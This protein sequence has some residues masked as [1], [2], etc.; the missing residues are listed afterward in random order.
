MITLLSEGMM[1]AH[2]VGKYRVLQRAYPH[3]KRSGYEFS[4]WK[5][6]NEFMVKRLELPIAERTNLMNKYGENAFNV[7]R[8]LTTAMETE[9]RKIAA[10]TVS[11]GMSSREATKAMRTAFNKTG[12]SK[13][14]PFVIETVAR[15]QLQLAYNAGRWNTYQDPA[16][17]EILWGFE[18]VT[19]GDDRVRTDHIALDG[20]RWPKESP[21]WSSYWPPNGYNCRCSTVEIFKGEKEADLKPFEPVKEADGSTRA[22]KPDKGWDFNGGDVFKE[23]S[24]KLVNPKTVQG[25]VKKAVKK[26]TP[27]TPVTPLENPISLYAKL[28]E[29][30]TNMIPESK[31]HG[32]GKAQDNYLYDRAAAREFTVNASLKEVPTDEIISKQLIA[33]R[34]KM[35]K[36]FGFSSADDLA[37]MPN[38]EA[39]IKAIDKY[40]DSKSVNVAA[41]KDILTQNIE[42]FSKQ[43]AA[44][45]PHLVKAREDAI[46]FF[47]KV[48]SKD[49]IQTFAYDAVKTNYR[50][51]V[52]REFYS[53]K[54]VNFGK[55][56]DKQTVFHEYAHHF[57][58]GNTRMQKLTNGW[59]RNRSNDGTVDR[60]A[61]FT[62]YTD[63]E[64]AFK[65]LF[66]T[67]YTGKIYENGFTEV[68]STGVEEMA[69]AASRLKH[70][71][72]DFD[73]FNF[74]I[75]ALSGG[76]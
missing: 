71:M 27:K 73:H 74:V 3:L 7:T 48:S 70:A 76:I 10:Q 22:P 24:S 34:K 37:A 4:I 59:L 75:E 21:F 63:K 58:H 54:T 53:N 32:L 46:D 33:I 20:S 29:E 6:A 28:P 60:L 16:I 39:R 36:D 5:S 45:Q 42:P 26:V 15:T 67:P 9:A 50:G 40:I 44:K 19:V 17:Q 51:N 52:T 72:G 57:E 18:Y 8:N 11:E 41:K 35:K 12:F 62:N 65:D 1:F 56:T 38:D 69:T 14:N 68:I 66:R 30:K 43:T 31:L 47:S 55:L 61:S 49:N 23:V 64:L 25:A 13:T 2:L